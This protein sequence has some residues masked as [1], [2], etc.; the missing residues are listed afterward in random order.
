MQENDPQEGADMV[1]GLYL[2]G[3][4]TLIG[5][6]GLGIGLLLNPSDMFGLGLP[7]LPGIIWSVAGVFGSLPWFALATVLDKLDKVLANQAAK[8]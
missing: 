8:P 7:L 3:I 2:A 6:V 5:G 1:M 4:L